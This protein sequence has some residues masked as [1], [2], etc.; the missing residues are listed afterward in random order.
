MKFIYFFLIY[1]LLQTSVSAQTPKADILFDNWEYFR[2][3]KLYTEVA[4]KKPGAAI[5]FKLGEC[6]RKMHL[7]RDEVAAYDK[8]NAF[9]LFDKSEF[10]LHYAVSLRSTGRD[11]DAKAAYDT[12]CSLAPSDFRG[13]FLRAAIDIANTDHQWDVPVTMTN[14]SSVNTPN[15]DL[16]PVLYKDGIV[17]TSNRKSPGHNKIYGWTGASYLD[18]YYAAKSKNDSNYTDVS[19]FGGSRIIKKFNDGPACFSQ[20]FDT[21]YI[22]RVDRDMS[23]TAN[24]N[25]ANKNALGIDRV[26][27][28]TSAMVHGKWT[29]AVPL[30]LNSDAYSVANPYLSKDGSRLYFVSDMPGGYGET[31]IY[32]CNREGTTW[33]QPLNMGGNVNTFNRESYPSEDAGGNFYFA[34]DG[35]QGFGGLDICVALNKHG[36]LEKAIPLKYPFNSPQD[37]FGIMFLRDMKSGYIT[38]N[39]YEGGTGDDDI[40]FFDLSKNTIN[41]ELTTTIYTIGYRPIKHDLPM[42]QIVSPTVSIAKQISMPTNFVIYFDLDKYFIRPDAI[43]HLDSLVTIMNDFPNL[44]LLASGN[45]DCRGGTDHNRKLAVKRSNAA[46]MYLNGKGINADRLQGEG[47]GTKRS[48]VKC[49]EGKLYSS[50]MHQLE[51]RAEFHL[52]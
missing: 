45:C 19:P 3:A 25:V 1:G 31:D 10:Y 20:N 2:A 47:Y 16:C 46:L 37:D 18:L 43:M 24:L 30:H 28:F 51:R 14:V 8:V 34:S 41:S 21:I 15:A 35:Y 7:Y 52:Q 40:F 39:R 42:P 27:I 26:K 38:S 22:S 33:G 11:A 44:T 13:P 23:T 12:Y 32:Y 50:D 17:F 6:Y 48:P 9:G 29:K 4:A 49:K 36:Q 5:Y